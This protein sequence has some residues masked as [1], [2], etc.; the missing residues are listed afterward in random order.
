MLYKEAILIIMQYAIVW[1]YHN[2]LNY[3]MS[4]RL[5]PFQGGWVKEKLIKTESGRGQWWGGL[6]RNKKNDI[7]FDVCWRWGRDSSF[8]SH[9]TG[10][11]VT[12]EVGWR[13]V[14]IV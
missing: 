3:L 6:G 5:F 4:F 8:N 12:E 1:T 11:Q 13:V 2:L 10:G 7:R 14:K 9:H